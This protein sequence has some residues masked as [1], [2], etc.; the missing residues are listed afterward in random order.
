MHHGVGSVHHDTYEEAAARCFSSSLSMP[1]F[2]L[3]TWL[4]VGRQATT[5]RLTS[6]VHG[7]SLGS[8]AQEPWQS[9][10]DWPPVYEGIS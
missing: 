8:S 1:C 3:F 9:A 4:E 5:N 2:L 7:P 10:P 6:D